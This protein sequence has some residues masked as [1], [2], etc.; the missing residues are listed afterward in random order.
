MEFIDPRQI[1]SRSMEIIG[2]ELKNRG[3]TPDPVQ[4]P[5]IRRVIHASA[6]F[7]FARTLTFSDHAAEKMR[8][9]I[10][11]GCV[12]VTDT[13]MAKA[14]IN[15]T[16]LEKFGGSVECFIADPDVAEEAK[17]RGITRSAVSMERAARIGRPV[18]F[19]IGNAPTALWKICDLVREGKLHPAGI[20][21]VP[22]G[23]V[24][25]V[26]SKEMVLELDCPY[27]VARGRKGGSPI[28]AAICNALIYGIES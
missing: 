4:D 7:D 2:Q 11:G 9:A 20:I 27:I 13:Q 17:E 24:N 25:V 10:R 28:A 16:R 26:E 1:E 3:I 12:I 21:G 14:G 19:A 15:K 22:V 23:F 8:D 5:I 18:L 6:D